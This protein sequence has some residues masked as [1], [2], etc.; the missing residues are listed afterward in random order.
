[1]RQPIQ[2]QVYAVKVTDGVRHYLMLRRNA[3]IGGFWQG[4]TGGVEE[5]H[6]YVFVAQVDNQQD[7]AID[8]R[9]HD[10]WQWCEFDRALGLLTWPGNIEGLLRCD[11]F[12]S[13]YFEAKSGSKP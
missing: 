9:E 11:R 12:L 6:E 1:M 7:P 10:Q 4:V 13:N 2:V 5:I 8:P 3:S